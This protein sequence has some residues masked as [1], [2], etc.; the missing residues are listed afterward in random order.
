M[1]RSISIGMMPSS[2]NWLFISVRI[3]RP[4]WHRQK[5]FVPIKCI[6]YLKILLLFYLI[7]M[8]IQ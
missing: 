6:I 1:G 3:K 5:D 8:I 7:F 2:L 4:E